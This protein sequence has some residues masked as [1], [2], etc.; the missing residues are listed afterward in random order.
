MVCF[1]EV[2]E[3]DVY[4]V[5]FWC[6]DYDWVVCLV[7]GCDCGYVVVDVGVVLVDYDVV[8]V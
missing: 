1:L 2:V 8:V 3:V 6:D 5:G 4:C 7:C